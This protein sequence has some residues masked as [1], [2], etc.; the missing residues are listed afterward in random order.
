MEETKLNKLDALNEL[1]ADILKLDIQ[2]K[3]KTEI[4]DHLEIFLNDQ[5]SGIISYDYN[6]DKA[7]YNFFIYSMNNY[8]IIDYSVKSQNLR[9]TTIR[10]NLFNKFKINSFNNSISLFNDESLIGYLS[11]ND[12][13][14][15]YKSLKFIIERLR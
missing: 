1:K 9:N 12:K 10:K 14:N 4:I 8:Y 6:I 2:A 7:Y 5:L 11:F 3:N 13:N 15:Y